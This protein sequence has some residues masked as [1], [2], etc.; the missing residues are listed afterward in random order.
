VGE[1]KEKD[2]LGIYEA[3][4]FSTQGRIRKSKGKL[5]RPFLKKQVE[6]GNGI[7]DKDWWKLEPYKKEP[8]EDNRFLQHLN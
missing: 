5:G 6:I 8:W 4:G 1:R 3:M 2:T 7:D